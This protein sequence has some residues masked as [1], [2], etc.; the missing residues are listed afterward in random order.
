MI[1]IM[2]EEKGDKQLPKE[3][4]FLKLQQRF[5]WIAFIVSSVSMSTLLR[6]LYHNLNEPLKKEYACQVP[7]PPTAILPLGIQ[8]SLLNVLR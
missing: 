6:N 8:F 7:S 4:E 2:D 1:L 3:R 5:T